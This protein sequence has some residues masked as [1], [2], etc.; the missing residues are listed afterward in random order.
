MGPPSLLKH[1]AKDLPSGRG[2]LSQEPLSVGENLAHLA[3]E[4]R[5]IDARES[6]RRVQRREL[7]LALRS[8]RENAQACC[9]MRKKWF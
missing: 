7:S 6:S 4:P 9:R 5:T 2:L 3:V 1:A 8:L